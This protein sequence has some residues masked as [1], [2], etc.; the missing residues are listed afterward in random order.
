MIFGSFLDSSLAEE[1]MI[2]T[3]ITWPEVGCDL[4]CLLTNLCEVGFELLY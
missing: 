4:G 2:L 1:W 3:A